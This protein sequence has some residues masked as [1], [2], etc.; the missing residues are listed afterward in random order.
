MDKLAILAQA[1]FFREL[2]DASRRA[3]AEIAIPRDVRPR[4]ILFREGDAGHSVYLVARGRIRLSR[5]G[6]HHRE[7]V[8]KVVR[9]GETFAEV[10]LFEQSRYP[11]TAAALTDTGVFLFPRRD[12]LALLE[13]TE[14]REDF[15]KMLLRRQRELTERIVYLT[16]YD[17]EQRLFRFLE[18]QCGADAVAILP[19]SKKDA[20]AAIGATPETL[21]R[22][23]LR[24]ER[25]GRLVWKGRRVERPSQPKP[26]RRSAPVRR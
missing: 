16:G 10:V 5:A 22:L 25:E 7:V 11:V 21:S 3:L 23:L 17:V 19:L 1:H 15:L 2:G 14:F 12:W 6:P 13:R 4:E 8:I 9:P 18:E 26:R 20:A 24:L